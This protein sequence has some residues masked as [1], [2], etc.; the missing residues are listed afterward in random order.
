VSVPMLKLQTN[1]LY[2]LCTFHTLNSRPCH[3]NVTLDT[4][5]SSFISPFWYQPAFTK[6]VSRLVKAPHTDKLNTP[7]TLPILLGS[8]ENRGI[9]EGDILQRRVWI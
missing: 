6:H 2:R 7:L 4:Q 8:M 1:L 9:I 3:T 5:T